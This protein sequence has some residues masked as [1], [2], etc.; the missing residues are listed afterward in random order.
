MVSSRIVLHEAKTTF[1]YWVI[2]LFVVVACVLVA[3]NL[4]LPLAARPAGAPL[5][6]SFW[7]TG[8]LAV[9][10]SLGIPIGAALMFLRIPQIT[11][12]LD[13]QRRAVALEYRRP[14]GRTVKEIPLAEV[15]AVEPLYRGQRRYAL[16]LRLASGETVRLDHRLLPQES[17]V[18]Q[19]ADRIN[20]QLAPY[21]HPR[22]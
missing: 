2:P 1:L 9:L 5:D 14:L 19:Q 7:L 8:A 13:T 3:A 17:Q 12:T 10:L 16:V 15:A 22:R 6:A 4:G 18:Q 20:A 21:W 11:T